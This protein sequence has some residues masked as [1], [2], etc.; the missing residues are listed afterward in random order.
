MRLVKFSN[1]KF[2]IRFGWIFHTYQDFKDTDYRWS[3]G[4]R[5]FKDCMRDEDTVRQFMNDC[6]NGLTE[7]VVA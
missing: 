7:R 5:F 4:H 2:G 6:G 1:G 3:K